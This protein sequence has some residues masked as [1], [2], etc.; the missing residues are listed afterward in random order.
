[1]SPS[2]FESIV[3]CLARA[4]FRHEAWLLSHLTPRLRLDDRVW[5][6]NSYLEHGFFKRTVLAH[7]ALKGDLG[8]CRFLVSKGP[9]I[10]AKDIFGQTPLS[11]ALKG[12][13][14]EVAA[15]LRQECD[16]SEPPGFEGVILDTW[17]P[18]HVDG[19][20]DEVWS[21]T[22]LSHDLVIV[23]YRS[24]AIHIKNSYTGDI[25][26]TLE[27]HR[28]CVKQILVLPRS[29]HI[30]S[31]SDDGS[32]KIWNAETGE[33][34]RTLLG[35]TDGVSSLV[36]LQSG[37]LASSSSNNVYLWNLTSGAGG[38]IFFYDHGISC[39]TEMPRNRIAIGCLDGSLYQK[40]LS[41]LYSQSELVGRVPQS[42]GVYSLAMLPDGLLAVGYST[43][44][45]RLWSV[46][47]RSVVR[48]HMNHTGPVWTMKVLPDGRLV[49]GAWDSSIRVTGVLAPVI[50]ST[51]VNTLAVLPD[52][53]LVS[54]GFDGRVRTWR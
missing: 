17:A 48:V 37:L 27:G 41:Y 20:T 23:G 35:S 40:D 39:I 32:I 46:K 47:D 44:I 28:A 18:I 50:S 14:H 16:A 45:I 1:M 49:S 3:P 38:S 42:G 22:P 21:L 43:G 33:C 19:R 29:T 5:R 51:S 7:A 26:K 54:G 52:G 6:S 24:G 10:N 8:R 36:L 13:H 9:D 15:F 11:E 34:T 4:G 30:V 2:S 25:V 53:R 31:G 12:G